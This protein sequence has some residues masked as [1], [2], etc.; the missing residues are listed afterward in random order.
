MAVGRQATA[1]ERAGPEGGSDV[2]RME[3]E[4]GRA[5]ILRRG[6]AGVCWVVVLAGLFLLSLRNYLLFHALTEV[7][8]VSVAFAIFMIVWNSQRFMQSGYMLFLGIAYLFIGAFDLLHTLAYKGMGVFPAG[9]ANLPTQLWIATRYLESL[10]F[11]IAPLFVRRR[12]RVNLAFLAYILVSCLLLLFIFRWRVFPVCFDAAAGLTAFKKISE[13]VIVGILLTSLIVLRRRAGEF[14]PRVLRWV[15]LSITLTVLSEIMFTLYAEPE[16]T[17]NAVGHLFKLAS[18]FV[19]YKALIEIGLREPYTVLYRDLKL[20]ETDLEK[21]RGELEGHVRQRTA[22][23]SQ[24]VSTLRDQVQ[25]RVM[26]EQRILA[27]QHQLRAL[28]G[29]LLD[30]EDKERREIATALHDSV[31]QILAFLKMELG[32]LQRSAL[33]EDV[34]ET[35]G[36]LREQVNEAIKR[37]R[38]LTFEISPPELYTLGLE[39]ALEELAQ[40]FGREWRL[41]CRVYD[42]E[43]DKP[44]SEQLKTLLYRSVRE[45]LINAAKH[46]RARTIDVTLSRTDG[47]IQIVVEDDGV[48][49][50]P[51]RLADESPHR[52]AGFGLFSIRE[53]LTHMGGNVYIESAEGRGTRVT[54]LAPLSQGDVA[55]Q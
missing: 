17:S 21:A 47:C 50:D 20:R 15:S 12:L 10:A 54:L 46:A 38:S 40:R 34:L 3:F 26:A 32:E 36:H 35:V 4:D 33:P 37:T 52:A 49:F 19:V 28:T 39:P 6:L 42:S 16:A 41:D 53:R 25:A 11:L 43:E 45:L 7:F 24:T 5:E 18:F 27:D 29:Q 1:A 23:L 48:G 14:D 8:S 31:G 44:L 55:L 13:Y 22:Q 9:G 2:Q 30:A 51:A